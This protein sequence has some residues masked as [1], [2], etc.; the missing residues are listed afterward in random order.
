MHEF[1]ELLN[2]LRSN[3]A[4]KELKKKIREWLSENPGNEQVLQLLKEHWELINTDLSESDFFRLNRV[5]AKIHVKA[6]MKL[7]VQ[8]NSN[9]RRSI[10]R[11]QIIQI[12][13]TLLIP[14]L[15]YVGIH[16]FI[17]ADNTENASQLIVETTGAK[18]RHFFLPDSTEVWLNSES[19]LNYPENINKTKQR[20]VSLS[21]QAYFKVYHDAA[22]PFAVQ[23]LQMD[24]RV[25]GTSFDVSAYPDEQTIS[26]TLEKG[27]IALFSK[28]GKQLEQLVPGEQAV[29]DIVSSTLKRENVK[30]TDFTSWT[31]GKLVFHNAGIIEVA[32]KLERR[33]GYTISISSELS[34]ENPTYTFTVQHES[35]NEICR[36][37]ELSTNARAT[38]DGKHIHFEKTE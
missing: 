14:V 25:L 5:L 3:P 27:S 17:K 10:N 31:V 1:Q 12:A 9:H 30:T 7:S 15:T 4:N 29:F 38:I 24:I 22:R 19:R 37:I 33:F 11:R 34:E 8:R 20:I 35:I 32:Q 16:Y 28:Q 36:L 6:N 26:S 18:I 23:T 2:Q 21:G 13:A